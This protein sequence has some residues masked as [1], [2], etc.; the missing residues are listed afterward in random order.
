VSGRTRCFL[1]RTWECDTVS[2]I[3]VLSYTFT[4]HFAERP[5][6]NPLNL[7][8]LPF[9]DYIL[10]RSDY[11][12]GFLDGWIDGGGGMKIIIKWKS[13][14]LGSHISRTG[15]TSEGMVHYLRKVF[16]VMAQTNRYRMS[17]YTDKRWKVK[18]SLCFNWAPCQ[19]GVLGE[20]RYSF[21]HS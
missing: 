13:F 14:Q 7:C 9:N 1:H 18:L 4:A 5:T 17:R 19:E 8:L 16:V 20:W 3:F 15:H 6:I 12:R 2:R 10:V 11:R 21:T